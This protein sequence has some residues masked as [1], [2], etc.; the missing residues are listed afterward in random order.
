MGPAVM[1][2]GGEVR[3]DLYSEK[4]RFDATLEAMLLLRVVQPGA[5][6]ELGGCGRE[7]IVEEVLRRRLFRVPRTL[8][9][10]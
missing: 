10:L 9:S 2:S 3:K 4:R 7:A 6:S 1:P 5:K 8:G